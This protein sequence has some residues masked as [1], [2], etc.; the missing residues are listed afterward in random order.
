MIRVALVLSTLSGPP[1]AIS[2]HDTNWPW[3]RRPTFQ[4]GVAASAAFRIRKCQANPECE[5]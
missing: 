1:K 2:S 5:W 4:A 3:P